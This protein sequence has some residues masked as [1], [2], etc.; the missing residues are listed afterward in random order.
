[1]TD[2]DTIVIGSGAGG[3]AAAVALAQ[4]GQRVLVCEQHEVPGGWMHSFTLE[5]YR[6]NT[7][8]H[9]IGELGPNERLRRIYEGLGV[10]RDLVFMELN[11]EGYDHIL[12]GAKRFDIPK[13][14]E[15]YCQRLKAAFP[16]EAR[17][18]ERLFNKLADV[19]HVLQQMIDER[20]LHVLD[21]PLALPWFARSGGALIDHYVRDPVLRGILKAQAGDHGMPPREVS[22][23]IHAA[24]IQ[25]YIEGAYHPLGGGMAIT[26]AFVRALRRAGGELRLKE[27]V[28]RIL[29]DGRRAAGVVLE[30]GQRLTASN[31][32]SNADPH[33]TFLRLIG[34][35]ALSPGLRRK[36]S[37]VGYS[38]SCLS[39]YLVVD[40]SL[41]TMGID[42]GNYWIYANSDIDGIYERAT[43]GMADLTQPEMIFATVTTLK[44]PSKRRSGRHQLELFSF[45]PYER[46]ERWEDQPSGQRDEAYQ[47]LKDA[48]SEG[49]IGV[50]DRYFPG[51]KDSI[52]FKDLGTPLTNQHYIR[53]Y[54]G[55][56]YG[57]DKGIWQAGPLGFRARTGFEGL[58]LCG[59]ST[60]AHGVAYATNSGL[61]AAGKIM[62]C[63]PQE[64][65]SSTEAE[66]TVC[67][68]EEPSTWPSEYRERNGLLAVTERTAA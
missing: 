27:P 57:I 5:G 60:M 30:N 15:A 46:F 56:I 6:F 55:N 12:L 22:A 1:M 47:D 53:A 14:R 43:R 35:E 16:N 24:V 51:I 3:L 7:G 66:L 18:I 20:W 40:C 59:A 64:F 67:Q 42:S 41:E 23:A 65:L 11:P 13:G 32:L 10:A 33:Q 34:P 58:Y 68:C 21:S 37:R 38:T 36:L 8:V 44:D 29:L 26:R 31:V 62:G 25:H 4:S 28:R 9:Y 17:G 39:L 52:V 2:Y 49:M 61:T 19:Y 48:I 50:V 54:R 45:A 63:E